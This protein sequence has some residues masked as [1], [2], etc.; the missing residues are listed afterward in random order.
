[1]VCDLI[2]V[3]PFELSGSWPYG[4]HVERLR[5]GLPKAHSLRLGG[6]FYYRGNRSVY[7]FSDVISHALVKL[8]EN[9]PLRL[10]CFPQ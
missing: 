5:L 8:V 4:S 2:Y 10:V 9:H 7:C 3:I 6:A 1:M